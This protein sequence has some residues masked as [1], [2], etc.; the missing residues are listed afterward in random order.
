LEREVRNVATKLGERVSSTG[1]ALLPPSHTDA[2]ASDH[3]DTQ[4]TEDSGAEK[5]AWKH[6]LHIAM[7]MHAEAWRVRKCEKQRSKEVGV[8]LDLKMERGIA[9]GKGAIC[10]IAQLV[11]NMVLRRR[12]IFRSLVN[13]KT[14]CSEPRPY[15]CSSLCY[16]V[17]AEDLFEGEMDSDTDT[18][19]D[20]DEE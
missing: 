7:D 19:M 18:D 2:G 17:S 13:R 10:S 16:S 11:A 6:D 1:N 20:L 8:L 3:F 4:M 14:T 12:D 5:C 9:P 15:L